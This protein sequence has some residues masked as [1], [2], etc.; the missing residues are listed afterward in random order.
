MAT[1]LAVRGLG[2]LYRSGTTSVEVFSN[3]TFDVAQGEVVALTGASGSGKTTLLNIIGTL[4]QATSG[5]V[6]INGQDI[7]KL[8]PAAMASFRNTHIGFIF[9]FHHLLPEFTAT[10]NVAMPSII[11]GASYD[12]ATKRAT[13]LLDEVGLAHRATHRPSE[14]SGGEAQR[15]AVARA[16][17]MQPTLVL[18]DEPT[19]NLDPENSDKLFS[20]ILSLAARHNQ[21]FLIATHNL[22]LAKSA[23]RTLHIEKG[24]IRA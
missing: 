9:Q 17:M 19:G 4:D 11:A 20:L 5:T 16:F 10:E 7:S 23:T 15:V 1:I 13:E 12:K 21:T 2:K 6:G 24:G 3:I 22:D 8:S 18:A 14:L